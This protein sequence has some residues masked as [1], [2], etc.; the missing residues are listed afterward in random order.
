M[1]VVKEAEEEVLKTDPNIVH[2]SFQLRL[3]R[4]IPRSDDDFEESNWEDK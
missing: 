4:R 2:V 3:G 1:E